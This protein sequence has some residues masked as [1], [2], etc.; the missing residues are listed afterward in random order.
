MPSP[1]AVS[2]F[3]L[4]GGLSV[5]VL[6]LALNVADQVLVQVA[7]DFRHRSL[8]AH[9][10]AAC[11]ALLPGGDRTRFR[12][13]CLPNCDFVGH[14][15]SPFPPCF[16]RGTQGRVGPARQAKGCF[17]GG[18]GTGCDFNHRLAEGEDFCGEEGE[19]IS[20]LLLC[21]VQQAVSA[22]VQG[23]IPKFCTFGQTMVLSA[24][25]GLWGVSNLKGL[26]IVC[27]QTMV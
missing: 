25:A 1:W 5:P 8:S 26:Q 11:D 2:G 17:F 16:S 3:G 9:V 4:T 27:G 12:R 20:A 15:F 7:V 24:G 21:E 22:E 18:T 10:R 23:K 6:D 13:C 14:A 19:W